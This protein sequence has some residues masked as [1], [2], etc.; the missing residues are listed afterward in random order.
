[1]TLFNK[2]RV[3]LNFLVIIVLS[4][5]TFWWTFSI[6]H[7]P[8]NW[9]LTLIVIVIRIVAS[10]FLFKDY[11]LSWSKATQRTFIIKSTVYIAAFFVYLPIFY[12]KICFGKPGNI[13]FVIRIFC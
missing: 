3:G 7:K 6:F 5:F 2:Y 11:T 8:F 10:I 13:S 4:L 1:M 9:K 12:N